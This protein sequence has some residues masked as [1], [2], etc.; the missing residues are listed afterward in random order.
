MKKKRRRKEDYINVNKKKILRI[1]F[2]GVEKRN[3]MKEIQS[4]QLKNLSQR[5]NQTLFT[6]KIFKVN[7]SLC[8]V[9]Q[10]ED[11]TSIIIR[12]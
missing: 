11:M 1:K 12:Y 7:V 2:W 8:M 3:E 10:E 9:H 5:R 4:P 6:T